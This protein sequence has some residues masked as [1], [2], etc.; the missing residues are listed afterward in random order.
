MIL[1]DRQTDVIIRAFK[2]IENLP[3][4]EKE[5]YYLYLHK[6]CLVRKNKFA[7][8]FS[9]W[10]I[11]KLSPL[12]RGFEIEI[13]GEENLP[14]N[15]SAVF[16]CNH[17]N[18]HDFF[19]TKEVF[20]RVRRSVVPL[21]AW[22]GLN[23][24]SRTLFRI[25]NVVLIKRDDSK[26]KEYGVID[27]CSKI[28]AG[29]DGLIF[30]EATWNL[31]PVLPMQKV[32]AG[33]TQVGLITGKP[34]IPMIYEYIEAPHIC[35][36]ESEL[37]RK[38]VVVFG[39]PIVVNVEENIF[40]QTETIQQ[41]MEKLRRN[42][43]KEFGIQKEQLSDIDKEVYL[44]HLYLKKYKALGFRYDSER[45]SRFLLNHENEYC[46]NQDGEFVPGIVEE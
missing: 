40:S 21:G 3:Y 37:Y 11:L 12:L 46:V 2:E 38:C 24:L 7:P 10:L 30:G 9:E 44:N 25:G 6:V 17:S 31:H 35:K 5:S 32:K 28:L 43:W 33:V 27:F 14:T 45:E 19:V 34:I 22:D 4:E 20:S 41:E 42:V 36:K 1:T 29:K 8:R 16:V 15:E 39:K 13:R 23:W 26:S 18:S